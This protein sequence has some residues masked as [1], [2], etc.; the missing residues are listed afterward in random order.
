M[1][2]RKTTLSAEQEKIFKNDATYSILNSYFFDSFEK[3]ARDLKI[4]E[5][6]EV[7]KNV[8]PFS[9]PPKSTLIFGDLW[10]NS[11][12][13]DTKSGRVWLLD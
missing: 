8:K 1:K 6:E 4:E 7:I 10:P 12:I 13:L 2:S 11:M 3:R 9:V 5:L